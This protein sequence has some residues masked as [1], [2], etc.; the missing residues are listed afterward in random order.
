M[1]KTKKTTAATPKSVEEAVNF[2]REA[3]QGFFANGADTYEKAMADAKD[4]WQKTTEGY[5]EFTAVNKDNVDAIVEVTN[6]YAKGVE[7][8]GAEW[9]AFGKSMM[10]SQI[11]ATQDIFASA[12]VKEAVEKQNETVKSSFEGWVAQSTKVGE[13]TNDLAKQVAVPMNERVS[14]TVAKMTKVAA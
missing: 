7:A 9:M 13:M 4:Q 12:S 6:V 5:D 10:E 11:K 1:T 8:I 14:A 2:G 3:W